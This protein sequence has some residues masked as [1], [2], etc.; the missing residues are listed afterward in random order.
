[1]VYKTQQNMEKMYVAAYMCAEQMLIPSS[2]IYLLGRI[3]LPRKAYCRQ[4]VSAVF[5][6][7]TGIGVI[8]KDTGAGK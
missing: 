5:P 2:D 7:P 8:G 4:P 1:M 6:C 3:C